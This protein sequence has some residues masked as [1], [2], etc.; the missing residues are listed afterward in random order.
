[1][2][3]LAA[4]A[5]AASPPGEPGD[6]IEMT[7]GDFTVIGPSGQ[8]NAVSHVLHLA[9]SR[10]SDVAERAGLPE[11][12]PV[13][14]H[15]A[16]TDEEFGLLTYGGVPDWG[17]GCAFPSRGVVVIRNP[18]TVPDPLGTEDVVAHEIA[19]IAAGRVL[20]DIR[21]PRWF[22]EGI[23]MTLAGEW[24]LP[25]SSALS[26]A[27]AGGRLI[28]LGDLRGP[29]PADASQAMLAYSESFYALRFLMDE[30]GSA[31]PAEILLSVAASGGFETGIE[32]LTGR[33][34][35][36]FEHDAVASFRRRFGW[37]VLLSRWNVLFAL[38]AL[39]LLAG[40]ALRLARSRRRMREWEEEELLRMMGGSVAPRPAADRRDRGD[41]RTGWN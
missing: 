24:R 16:S 13:D 19:H 32:S 34:L 17:V 7:E 8:Q 12:G 22:H 29:F 9:A 35:A 6:R 10:G 11:L 14:I 18:V 1:M 31:T 3:C 4:V 23:A 37:G 25:R 5:P 41:K 2:L 38:L 30:A 27:G 28:P 40:G 20:G 33:T 21:V 36:E 15:I 39:L 26:S